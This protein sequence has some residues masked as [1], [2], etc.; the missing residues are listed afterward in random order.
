MMFLTGCALSRFSPVKSCHPLLCL[1]LRKEKGKKRQIYLPIFK[2]SRF[3][4]SFR[5]LYLINQSITNS[6]QRFIRLIFIFF[7]RS[8]YS[9]VDAGITGKHV[10]RA[11]YA[12]RAS[13]AKFRF[14]QQ[15][16]AGPLSFAGR[17]STDQSRCW[18]F[19]I[20]GS[21]RKFLANDLHDFVR[22][23]EFDLLQI[24]DQRG[25]VIGIRL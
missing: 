20:I 4:I 23:A 9:P 25:M 8:R 6:I 24:R 1:Y 17:S 15:S 13:S 21:A 19:S 16:H 5:E 12:G 11:Q 22:Y 14:L 18:S 2:I 10:H 7:N 3:K